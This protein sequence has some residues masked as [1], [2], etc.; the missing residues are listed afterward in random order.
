M[1]IAGAD[2]ASADLM[3]PA[4][5]ETAAAHFLLK[6]VAAAGNSNQ[7]R[8][9]WATSAISFAVHVCAA[10]A[11]I[12]I[13]F[14]ETGV[15]PSADTATL[16]IALSDITEQAEATDDD[17]AATLSDVAPTDGEQVAE[18]AAPDASTDVPVKEVVEFEPMQKVEPKEEASASV[19]AGAGP[20]DSLAA[21]P[22][23]AREFRAPPR[24]E[25]T[26]ERE[27]RKPE[28]EK[29]NTK[30]T[31]THEPDKGD[32]QKTRVAGAKSSSGSSK[33]AAKGGRA[34][35]SSGDLMG[36]A[37]R[38]RARVASNRPAGAGMRGTAV[39]SF[40]VTSG[41][42]LA[43]ARLSRS[44]GNSSLDEAALSAVRRAAP[45]PPPPSGASRLS[46]SVPFSFR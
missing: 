10:A 6:D 8:R 27:R 9:W 37:A 45:F 19:V 14:V 15:L 38:V 36:Y 46:F 4:E 20:D 5:S 13:P 25:V 21:K 24:R 11:F 18:V 31:V 12:A 1:S 33:K 3:A 16:E 30:K 28:K 29:P 39:V 35:A 43:Y 23:Q 41:G 22:S 44:S 40:G 2:T 17:A 26:V 42:G 32:K 34:S 7:E